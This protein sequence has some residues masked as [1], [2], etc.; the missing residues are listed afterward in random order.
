MKC[1]SS[2]R[3]VL[4]HHW[5]VQSS[6]LPMIPST[7]R[8]KAVGEDSPSIALD[9]DFLGNEWLDPPRGVGHSLLFIEPLSNATWIQNST[10]D[11]MVK[12]FEAVP[13]V[14]DTVVHFSHRLHHPFYP[15]YSR[16]YHSQRTRPESQH[17]HSTMPSMTR[18]EQ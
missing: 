8:F 1:T 12:L 9:F 13:K 7:S 18:Q 17:D 4:C 10:N 2:L 11:G 6:I 14:L 5:L 3:G 16:R 15:T